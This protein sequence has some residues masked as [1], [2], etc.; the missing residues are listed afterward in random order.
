MD[1]QLLHAVQRRLAAAQEHGDA[2]Q[3]L[4]QEAIDDAATLWRAATR[5]PGGMPVRVVYILA[6]FHLYRYRMALDED[7][8]DLNTAIE[9]FALLAETA[10]ELVPPE[11][12]PHFSQGVEE[13]RVDL[14]E[15]EAVQL[16]AGLDATR[17]EAALDRAVLL[18]QAAISEKG[19]A[20]PKPSLLVNLGG[21]LRRRYEYRG[22]LADCE[23][24]IALLDGAVELLPTG[25][26]ER[27]AAL[28]NLAAALLT[29]FMA[30]A[31]LCDLDRA[32]EVGRDAVA[33]TDRGDPD[34]AGRLSNLVSAL[35]A[36]YERTGEEAD[37]DAA[38]R[39][40]RECF[41]MLPRND[42]VAAIVVGNLAMTTLEKFRKSGG[43]AC[44]GE[45]VDLFAETLR[46]AGSDHPYRDVLVPSAVEALMMAVTQPGGAGKLDSVVALLELLGPAVAASQD[47]YTFCLDAVARDLLS[48][49]SEDCDPRDLD[50][51]IQ[52]RRAALNCTP[53]TDDSYL[54]RLFDLDE[55]LRVRYD[56]TSRMDDLRESLDL[57]RRGIAMSVSG[58]DEYSAALANFGTAMQRVFRADPGSGRH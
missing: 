39:A 42:G 23:E 33:S 49:F 35:R 12:L 34:L 26:A 8:S 44:L 58:S 31:D 37:L 19:P 6:W 24:A 43:E 51:A 53:E 41:Q 15:G 36:R 25:H 5:E 29:R 47:V 57:A 50:L 2:A 27:A 52:H 9:L 46:L 7:F 11:L 32:I 30:T 45:A 38:L 3:V 22:D 18:L 13:I 17:D 14:W 20:T 55:A 21:A 10:P 28:T 4:C 56:R 48:R 40:G 54:A 16:L 1:D